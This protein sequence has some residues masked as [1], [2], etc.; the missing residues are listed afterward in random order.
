ML[1]VI[2]SFLLMTGLTTALVGC[3]TT[4][5]NSS[6]LSYAPNDGILSYGGESKARR[7]TAEGEKRQRSARLS[8]KV[9]RGKIQQSSQRRF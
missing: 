1:R 7:Y 4:G 2:F 3:G 9:P 5:Q 6:T 8:D